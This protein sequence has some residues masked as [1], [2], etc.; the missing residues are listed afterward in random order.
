MKPQVIQELGAALT[1]LSQAT[2]RSLIDEH[3]DKIIW[4]LEK[5]EWERMSEVQKS[6]FVRKARVDSSV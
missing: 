5:E 6:A 3:F 2:A 1:E 4:S